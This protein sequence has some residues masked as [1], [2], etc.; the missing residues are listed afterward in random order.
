MKAARVYLGAL[1]RLLVS[2]SRITRRFAIWTIPRCCKL[3][4]SVHPILSA[5]TI[6][7]AAWFGVRWWSYCD[8]QW[9]S[10]KLWDIGRLELEE[11]RLLRLNEPAFLDASRRIARRIVTHPNGKTYRAPIFVLRIGSTGFSLR[12]D[13]R[14]RARSLI[15]AI[16]RTS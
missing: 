12:C 11:V 4:A 10:F 15:A 7:A 5:G 14:K 2:I 9:T 16:S 6:L 8:S 3:W 13:A 1:A